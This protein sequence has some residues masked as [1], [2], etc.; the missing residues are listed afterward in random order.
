M[1]SSQDTHNPS[2]A[3]L[4]PAC[5][6][7]SAAP[8][9]FVSRLAPP[10]I[11]CRLRAFRCSLRRSGGSLLLLLLLLLLLAKCWRVADAHGG[12]DG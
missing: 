6:I 2:Y 7:F 4:P 3:T 9:A 1:R 12:R 8:A 5:L 11:A 10:P